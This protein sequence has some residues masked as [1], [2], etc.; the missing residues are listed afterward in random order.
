MSND[1]VPVDSPPDGCYP[2][3]PELPRLPEIRVTPAT[4]YDGFLADSR[5]ATTRQGRE[6][7][8]DDFGRFMQMPPS[9]ACAVLINSSRGEAVAVVKA[10]RAHLIERKLSAATTNRRLSTLRSLVQYAADVELI[11]WEIG[12][13]RG[14]ENLPEDHHTDTAGPGDGGWRRMLEQLGKDAARTDVGRRN[15]AICRL[16]HDNLLRCKELLGLDLADWDPDA[17]RVFVVAKGKTDKVP[18]TVNTVTA[19]A[20]D[21]WIAAR[22]QE[23]GA[24]FTRLDRA[25]DRT[26]LQRITKSAVEKLVR[27]IGTSAGLTRRVKPHGLRHA[28]VTRIL[29]L[30]GGN[31]QM[32][33]AAAGHA[34]PATTKRYDDN[35][36]DLAGQAARLLGD[37]A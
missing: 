37:D 24:L 29:E 27:K 14:V 5:K 32:A 12:R 34:N 31:I 19:A 30:S 15:L 2:A 33:Q 18:K 7:D 4:V 21:R 36:Q 10:Y 25:R 17:G 35:R 11:S 13:A 26:A 1:L 8:L 9:V 23:P 20:I 16:A 28:G 3:V 6:W 22:G